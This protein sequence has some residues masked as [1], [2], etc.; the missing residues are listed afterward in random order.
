MTPDEIAEALP[1][2][3]VER[4]EH[5]RRPVEAAGEGV[6]AIDALVRAVRPR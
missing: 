3:E 4:A 5:V 2:L 1:G 6:Y